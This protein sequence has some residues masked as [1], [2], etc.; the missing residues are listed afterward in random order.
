MRIV[1]VGAEFEEN[2]AVRCLW[3]ALEKEGHEVSL[4]VFN[5][6]EDM[7]SAAGT[8]IQSRAELAGFSMVFTARS[9]E[10]ADLAARARELGFAGHIVAGG[11]F[12]AFNAE[13]LLRDVSAI[14]SVARGEG[15]EIMCFLAHHLG[16]LSAVKG[17]VWRDLSGTIV[18][19]EPAAKP[20]DLDVLPFPHHR[21]PFDS[22]LGIPIV[23]MLSSRGCTH[24]C[25]FCS[26]SAW[27]R[28]CGGARHRMRSPENVAQEMA[29]LYSRGVR[30]FN[31]HDDNFLP[32]DH[33]E[34]LPRL[35][36]LGREMRRLGIGR[37]GFAIKARPDEVDEEVFTRLK[38][39]GLFRVFL[40]VEAGSATSL[41]NLGRGQTL[42][43]N[44]RALDVLN[45]LDIHACF[46]LLML[47]PDSTLEDFA[48]NVAFLREHPHNPMN[49]CR[50]EI[51]AGTPLEAKLRREGRLL[52]DY[53]GYDYRIADPRAQ[54][55][56]EIIY[57]AFRERNY[58]GNCLHHLTMQVDYEHQILAHF[59][60][61]DAA[62]R[63]R[64][65]EF[66]VE[67][68]LDTC[69]H[70]EGIVA[71]VEDGLAAA[72]D[73]TVFAREAARSVEDDNLRL[74]RSGRGLLQQI[75]SAASTAGQRY[76]RGWMRTAAAGVV[77]AAALAT[78]GCDKVG[79]G[80]THVFE[81]V[82]R[83]PG[84]PA[85]PAPP[86]PPPKPAP[87]I[88]RAVIRQQFPSHVLRMIASVIPKG[89]GVRVTLLV[90]QD[91]T[92]ASARLAALAPGGKVT[93]LPANEQTATAGALLHLR[94]QLPPESQG[95]GFVL[96]FSAA[97]LE[98][99]R[100]PKTMMHEMVPAPHAE[101]KADEK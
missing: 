32:C 36:A 79:G 73:M 82:R 16:N 52:G 70:L 20:A 45:R 11:H 95:Q 83:P 81:T 101:P 17:L 47:N 97:E 10:F 87:M 88:D 68:N 38:E 80:K 46:N 23:N 42:S 4:A 33:A 72:S 69:K 51:Y 63:Q 60:R 53:W 14:N 57:P 15:E 7:E 8:I 30:I 29:L 44:E 50:T 99:A 100:K 85:P 3:A 98:E 22:F 56:F 86:Q 59:H 61:H 74:S 31:F 58:G 18:T 77:V 49:F 13:R 94:F 89:L 76:R 78:P 28:L 35:E 26:I 65:K 21:Q 41:K 55:L 6:L 93:D 48:A 37:I 54:T 27:H 19:N 96:D 64:V 2:L 75:C 71:A 62:L 1:L 43:D 5:A 92:V 25:S 84:P 66:V 40:G 9:H 34:R 39:M 91:G 24:A 12:A 67:V 90:K